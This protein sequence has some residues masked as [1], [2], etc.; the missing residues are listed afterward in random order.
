MKKWLSENLVLASG[1][2]LPV[3]LIGAFFILNSA[4]KLLS[5]PPKYDFIAVAYSYDYQHRSNYFLSFEVSDG[6]LKGKALPS[7]ENATSN[8]QKADVLR[9][10]ASTNSF[11][12]LIYDLPDEVE[13]IDEPTPLSLPESDKLTLDKRAQSPDG[14]RFEF[15]GY[16]GRGG[17]L[18]EIFGTRS[19]YESG[20]ILK[21]G[22]AAFELPNPTSNANYYQNNLEF[23]GWISTEG[24]EK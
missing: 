22:N 6:K 15:V 8:R 13:T 12:E 19:R 14:Y 1:I 9:Y 16:R 21:K 3:L 18:G 4:P 7:K 5:D 17:L 20:Y 11:E 2:L 24:G 23:M 10:N